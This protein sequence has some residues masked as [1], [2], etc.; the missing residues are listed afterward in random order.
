[1][2]EENETPPV[3]K[4]GKQTSEFYVTLAGMLSAGAM[5]AFGIPV[6]PEAILATIGVLGSVYTAVRGLVKSKG[7]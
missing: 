6:P 3:V 1:M 7:K 4:P 5:L 2:S